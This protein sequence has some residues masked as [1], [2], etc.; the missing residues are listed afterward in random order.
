MENLDS[1]RGDARPN[2]SA[3]V[4]AGDRATVPLDLDIVIDADIPLKPQGPLLGRNRERLQ[5]RAVKRLEQIPAAGVQ[6][7]GHLTVELVKERVDRCVG[8]GQ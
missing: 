6:M 2:R 3:Q 4:F 8:L 7:A 5:R 1:S